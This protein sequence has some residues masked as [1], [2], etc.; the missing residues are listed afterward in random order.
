M[1]IAELGEGFRINFGRGPCVIPPEEMVDGR[2]YEEVLPWVGTVIVDDRGRVWVERREPGRGGPID[3]FDEAGVYQGTVD[4]PGDRLLDVAPGDRLIVS[5]TDEFGVQ[6][7]V[8][9]NLAWS[10]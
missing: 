6:R 10:S 1:A 3:L 7:V 2:G 9:H 4:N 8:V 5:K